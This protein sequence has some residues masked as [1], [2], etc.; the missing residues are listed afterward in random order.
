V[1]WRCSS[2]THTAYVQAWHDHIARQGVHAPACTCHMLL[3]VIGSGAF[4]V[5]GS[6]DHDQPYD[7]PWL[8]LVHFLYQLRQW[9]LVPVFG[10]PTSTDLD[11]VA[12]DS[13][14]MIW[15][16]QRLKQGLGLSLGCRW[17][18]L[19]EPC[20]LCLL[21]VL[22]LQPESIQVSSKPRQQGSCNCMSPGAVLSTQPTVVLETPVARYAMKEQ[23][24]GTSAS[25]CCLS[26][27]SLLLPLDCFCKRLCSLV[28][29]RTATASKRTLLASPH[30]AAL[31]ASLHPGRVST[32]FFTR[33]ILYALH[34]CHLASACSNAFFLLC[35]RSQLAHC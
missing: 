24:L 25:H 19:Y 6:L 16:A 5:V 9:L 30:P 31:K 18:R 20:I 22:A 29:L 15:D 14:D 10:S 7:Q 26:K 35:L 12:G 17:L 13:C 4:Q 27:H 3:I 2:P 21:E 28:V 1:R 8:L 32:S 34:C 23:C 33:H 11:W